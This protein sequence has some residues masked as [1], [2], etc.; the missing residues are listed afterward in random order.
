MTIRA[1][2]LH[3]P[4]CR[5]RCGYCN[6]S[7]VADRDDLV[8]AYLT[9]LEQ[10][11]SWL[12]EP[13]EVD[14]LFLGGGTPTHLDAAALERLLALATRWFPPA[15]GAE[16][17][18][19]ANPADLDAAKADI[20]AAAGVTR[21]SFGAQSFDAAKLRTL[22]RDHAPE[23]TATSLRLARDRGLDVSL[24]LIFGAP[25][26]TLDG[27]LGDLERAIELSP[28]H[29]S[30]YGLTFERGTT[31]W[32][33]RLRGDLRPVAEEEE[34][35]MYAR[36]I[37]RLATAGYEHYEVSNFAWPRKRCRHNET[38][39]RGDEYH[40][41]GPGAARYVD[42]RRETNHRST[43]AWLKRVMAGQ[44]PVAESETLDSE[45]RAREALV[46]AL[47]TIEGVDLEA[48][49]TRFGHTL[50]SLAGRTLDRY[51]SAGWLEHAAGSLRLTRPGLFIS[52]SLWTALLST[53]SG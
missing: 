7:V 48:F 38:Y 31:F 30:T 50:E 25:G 28:D 40:A 13:R 20:L 24:D 5:R 32:G 27:W 43:T 39:W 14:T 45:S 6:F 11:L 15:G 26:E 37:D 36:A 52:D 46:L 49:A 8:A 53:P 22:E 9:A 21:V 19:E 44:S 34:L 51:V 4:F 3:V 12:S 35:A 41:A 33:R 2:Y 17:S 18:I 47:R 10:E 29:V 42:G 1:A 16:F 23:S